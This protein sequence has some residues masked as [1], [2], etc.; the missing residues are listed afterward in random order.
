LTESIRNELKRSGEIENGVNFVTLRRRDLS[1]EELS[2]ATRISVGDVV[3]LGYSRGM[4]GLKRDGVHEVVG[5]AKG[6]LTV[7][8]CEGVEVSFRPRKHTITGVYERVEKEFSL[9]DRV[10]WTRND[11]ALGVRNGQDAVV[12]VVG[13]KSI[14]LKDSEGKIVTLDKNGFAHLDHNYVSTVFGSQGK[15][16]DN[17]IVCADETFGKEAVYVAVSRARFGIRIFC[18]DKEKFFALASESRAKSSALDL[19]KDVAQKA[20]K[21]NKM[22]CAVDG[23]SVALRP[24]KTV[25]RSVSR[26]QEVAHTRVRELEQ[27]YS[28]GI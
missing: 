5:S 1:T 2:C 21:E 26:Q 25:E 12:A 16:C 9:G 6:L 14:S 8:S 24:E 11:K 18:E 19:V 7:R 23:P 13:E 4:N 15:T 22:E 20:E 27:D 3:T 17:V 28:I 10:R